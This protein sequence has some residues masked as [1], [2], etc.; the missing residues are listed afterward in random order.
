[1]PRPGV[2]VSI[3]DVPAPVSIPTDTGISFIVGETDRGPLNATLVQSLSAF[4]TIYGPRTTY[5]LLFDAVET[6]Y[7]EG[8]YSAYIA[9]VVGPAATVGSLNLL[10][11]SAAISLVASANGPG[12][13]SSNYKVGVVAGSVSGTF[14]IQVTDAGNE[15]LEDSGDLGTQGAAVQWSLY[16]NYIRLTAGASALNPAPAAP[17]A[18][19]AGT[20]DRANITDAQWKSALDAFSKDLGPGQVIAPGRTTDVGHNQIEDHASLNNRVALLDLPDSPTAATLLA[21]AAAARGGG[22]RFG[23]SFAPW[24]VVPG[25]V[26]GTVR[27]VP[28]SGAVAGLIARNDNTLGVNRP[29]AGNAGSLRTAIGLSQPAWDDATRESLNAGSVN[30][31][32]TMFNGIRVYGWRSLVNAS[33]DSNW[34]NFANSRLIIQLK[35]E[36]DEVGENFVFSEIDGQN[37]ITI[38]SFNGGLTGVLLGHFLSGELFGDTP[39]QAFI[40]DTGP[41]VNTLET[42]ANGELH[43]V[44]QV[45]LSP[46]AEWVVIQIVKRQ[47][48]EVF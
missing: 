39:G 18:L 47:V 7:K 46:F 42:I 31:I 45:K 15:V 40:V 43:A 38:T 3:V 48:T 29:S 24:L 17:T 25:V 10:D 12:A 11:G 36:L 9:R 22:Q 16:S 28:P 44:C 34:V 13:W 6:F 8:G 2:D 37:G 30:V 23:A 26:L 27:V 32:R 19:S 4:T 21:S 20:D 35:A 1:M 5:S 33:T 41:T 14:V